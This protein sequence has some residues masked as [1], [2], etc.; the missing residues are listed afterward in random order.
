MTSNATKEGLRYTDREMVG[1]GFVEWCP[2]RYLLNNLLRERADV[3]ACEPGIDRLWFVSRI[4][5]I[6]KTEE[7]IRNLLETSQDGDDKAQ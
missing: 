6:D 2:R 4:F 7:V 3:R 5:V 1:L